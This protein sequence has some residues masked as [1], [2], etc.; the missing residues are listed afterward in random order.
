MQLTRQSSLEAADL[1]RAMHPRKQAKLVGR[2]C[3]LCSLFEVEGI[4]SSQS[5]YA[6]MRRGLWV[7]ISC[8]VS[9]TI[10]RAH[11]L[12]CLGMLLPHDCSKIEDTILYKIG[13]CVLLSAVI[14]VKLNFLGPW[15]L[16]LSHTHTQLPSFCQVE[17]LSSWR[18]FPISDTRRH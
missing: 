9:F 12:H 3:E 13:W 2:S 16:S 15:F 10:D 8:F 18:M 17:G 7:V 4:R 14:L 5:A 11:M 1:G 6:K